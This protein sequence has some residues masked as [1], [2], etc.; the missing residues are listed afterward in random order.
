VAKVD[1]EGCVA[2]ATCVKVRPY[3]APMINDMKKAEILGATCAKHMLNGPCDGSTSDRCEVSADKPCAWQ[4]IFKRLQ[5]IGQL[6]RLEKIHPLKDW[7]K[8]WHGGARKIVRPE[9]RI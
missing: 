5:S 1:P 4:L 6:D 3:G 2:C 8:A 7:S 9:H